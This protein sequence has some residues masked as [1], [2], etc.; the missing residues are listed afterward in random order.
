MEVFRR[1]SIKRNTK[2]NFDVFCDILKEIFFVKETE[3]S[4]LLT[5]RE[6]KILQESNLKWSMEKKQEALDYIE[7][8]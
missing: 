1:I 4:I 8:L 5:Q 6:I 2:V 7:N 3:D